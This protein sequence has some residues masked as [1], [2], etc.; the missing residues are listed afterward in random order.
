MIMRVRLHISYPTYSALEG[1]VFE[2]IGIVQ[3]KVVGRWHFAGSHLRVIE[4]NLFPSHPFVWLFLVV[5]A[6]YHQKQL[7]LEAGKG[8]K[9]LRMQQW[10]FI[11]NRIHDMVSRMIVSFPEIFL[12]G[13]SWTS[14]LLNSS[15]NFVKSSLLPHLD[16][17]PCLLVT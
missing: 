3:V 8:S 10:Y 1:C 17:C 5:P 2:E 15:S 4:S 11:I 16:T 9:Q 13:Y 7:H 6:I 12:S 14:Q